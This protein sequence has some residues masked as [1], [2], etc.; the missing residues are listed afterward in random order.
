MN[1]VYTVG[2]EWISV[3]NFILKVIF[4]TC[5]L[6]LDE[7]VAKVCICVYCCLVLLC[8]CEEQW[9]DAFR[10]RECRRSVCVCVCVCVYCTLSPPISL[11]SLWVLLKHS[12][13]LGVPIANHQLINHTHHTSRTH[14]AEHVHTHTW[15][16]LSESIPRYQLVTNTLQFTTCS[17]SIIT[18]HTLV[19]LHMKTSINFKHSVV[20]VVND[21]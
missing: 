6:M 8:V 19:S 3:R 5:T 4:K 7:S 11:I 16:H 1:V 12:S 14:R 20:M 9:G 2:S 10:G 17:T 13:L 18:K 15:I 21:G